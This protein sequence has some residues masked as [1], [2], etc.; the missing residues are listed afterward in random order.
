MGDLLPKTW[1]HLLSRCKRTATS[2][3][4][5]KNGGKKKAR[6]NLCLLP[7][8]FH[9]FYSLKCKEEESFRHVVM[10]AKK[11]VALEIWQKKTKEVD[12]YDFPVHDCIQEQNGS[13]Y[14]SFIVRQCKWPSLS[15][16]VVEIQKLP[17]ASMVT[18]CLALELQRTI[19]SNKK[20]KKTRV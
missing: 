4:R 5:D 15:R 1:K 17:R 18:E 10:E 8:G 20:K 16:K 2:E 6:G 3:K 13:P 11:T 14:L 19:T 12:M 9:A 7:F